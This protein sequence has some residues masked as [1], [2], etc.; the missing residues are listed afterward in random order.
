MDSPFVSSRSSQPLS[1]IISPLDDVVV[2]V[3]LQSFSSMQ[4]FV[5]VTTVIAV[6]LCWGPDPE[7]YTS[8]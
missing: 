6:H 7:L 1:Q 5:W 2:G 3:L 8:S 4:S